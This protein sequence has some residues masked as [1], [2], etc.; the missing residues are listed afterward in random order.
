[1][2]Q[3]S[4]LCIPAPVTQSPRALLLSYARYRRTWTS[5]GRVHAHRILFRPLTLIYKTVL[6]MFVMTQEQ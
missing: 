5:A 1:M 4:S 2:S 6:H 3:R